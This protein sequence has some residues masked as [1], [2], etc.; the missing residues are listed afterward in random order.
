MQMEN[1]Y[2]KSNIIKLPYMDPAI[3]SREIG[4]FVIGT[5]N[6]VNATGCVIGLSGRIRQI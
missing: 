1:E 5:V 2:E 3:V 4:D 6:D